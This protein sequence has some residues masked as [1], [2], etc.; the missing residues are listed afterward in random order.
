LDEYVLKPLFSYAG[1]GV[2]I[3]VKQEDIDAIPDP[4]NW[5]LQQKVNY[6][7]VIETPDG[8]AKAEIRLFYFWKKEWKRPLAVHNLARLS[9]GKMIGTRYNENENWVGG[10]I[11][12]FE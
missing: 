5:I 2:K 1:M 8:N 3:D 7:D 9:K 10:T 6:A 11:A 4:E 12:Y